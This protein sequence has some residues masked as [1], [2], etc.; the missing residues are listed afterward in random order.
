MKTISTLSFP[1]STIYYGSSESFDYPLI[2][3]DT[4]DNCIYHHIKAFTT[5][6]TYYPHLKYV[7]CNLE[8]G[9]LFLL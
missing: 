2:E 1:I 5:I 3:D 6:M 7:N 8:K 4:L 9:L